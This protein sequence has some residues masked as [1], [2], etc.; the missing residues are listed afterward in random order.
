[1]NELLF[2]KDTTWRHRVARAGSRVGASEAAPARNE[3]R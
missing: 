3:R 1:M 2:I